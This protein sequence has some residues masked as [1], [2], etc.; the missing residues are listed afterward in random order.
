MFR[1]GL[2]HTAFKRRWHGLLLEM[3]WIGSLVR[4]VNAS[5]FASTLAI[6]AGG[7]VPL[8]AALGSAARVMTN[9]VMVEAIERVMERVRE[10]TSL[11]RALAETHAFPPLLV[12]LVASGEASGKLDRML[13]RAAHLESQALERRLAVFLTLLEPV[14]ILV[15]GGVVLMIVLAILLPIIEINQLVR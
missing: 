13:K 5:R 14:M 15:M 12:H 1:I 4:G 9:V 3:P 10:G 6:L 11:A 7:G 2:R 8:L